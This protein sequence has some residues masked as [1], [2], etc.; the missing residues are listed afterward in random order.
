M[1]AFAL[2]AWREL[3][4]RWIWPAL[5]HSVWIGLLTASLA[6]L[7][8]QAAVK[9]THRARHAILLS[10]L[11]L[12]IVGPVLAMALQHA[13]A[14]LLPLDRTASFEM[15]TVTRSGERATT[16]AE[17]EH[18]RM[19]VAPLERVQSQSFFDFRD[20]LASFVRVA[21]RV[22]SFLVTVWLLCVMTIGGC[23]V[24]GANSL[25]R[26]SRQAEPAAEH[27]QRTAGAM[28]RRLR[29]ARVPPVLVHARVQEPFLG[30]I[31][32]PAILLPGRAIAGIRRDRLEAILAHELAHARRLDHIINLAQRMVEMFLFFHPAVHWLSRSLRRQREF[33]A[34]ALAV[35]LTSDPLALAGALESVALLRLSSAPAPAGASTL[36]GHSTFLLPRIQELLGMKPSRKRFDLWPL[37][38]LPAAGFSALFAASAGVAQDRPGQSVAQTAEK[39]AAAPAQKASSSTDTGSR[40][41]AVPAPARD[42]LDSMIVY[43]VRFLAGNP[44]SLRGFLLE[45]RE[46]PDQ[47]R[48]C[49]AWIIDEKTLGDWLKRA[50]ADARTKVVHAPK[51]TAF[52]EASAK[53][54][55]GPKYKQRFVES[56]KLESEGQMP[57]A[58]PPSPSSDPNAEQ[59]GKG[60][61][62]SSRAT[63][64]VKTWGGEFLGTMLQVKGTILPG[65]IRVSVDVRDSSFIAEGAH[66]NKTESAIND[67]LAQARYSPII[68]RQSHVAC[69]IP[70]G[71]YL[72]ICM[73]LRP[74]PVTP[75]T[76]TGP[77]TG[78]EPGGATQ[79][80]ARI[81]AGERLF[82]F[83][84]GAREAADV[85][86]KLKERSSAPNGV[87]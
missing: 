77:V 11:V 19:S 8:L 60:K 12:V 85:A 38:A 6:A 15:I 10:G 24:L 70:S 16:V 76:A 14:V 30:G 43:D 22:R 20:Q 44:K 56:M 86:A 67:R 23:F 9:C 33:C 21:N 54:F 1:Q 32:R 84:L 53:V 5:L 81:D 74:E 78:V 42:D 75:Y 59:P 58:G 64:K 62:P 68:E 29:L 61:M 73:G 34:D 49:S 55:N 50:G 2:E 35:R 3:S 36:G 66:H 79:P 26:L 31:F 82:V 25:L 7:L 13:I 39:P 80:E 87:R 17:E 41:I 4:S 45:Q 57:V 37:A 51:I 72:A 40:P 28:A 47:E 83:I 63:V 52:E 48:D 71:S 46:L 18:L 27:I 69:E 65:K